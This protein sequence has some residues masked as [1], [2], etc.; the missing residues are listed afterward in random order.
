[1]KMRVSHDVIRKAFACCRWRYILYLA[2]R[3]EKG[4]RHVR[5]SLR[6]S[7]S[8]ALFLPPLLL[9][10]SRAMSPKCCRM[11]EMGRPFCATCPRE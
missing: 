6:G 1:M 3:K 5:E 11:E 10:W 4:E 8:Y 9:N 2:G 7:D